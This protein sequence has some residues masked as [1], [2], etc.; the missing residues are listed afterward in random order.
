VET[1]SVSTVVY[2]HLGCKVILK[3]PAQERLIF[4][5]ILW[6]DYSYTM[7]SLW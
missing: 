7:A 3:S 1:N 4:G 6:L 2:T 5:Y